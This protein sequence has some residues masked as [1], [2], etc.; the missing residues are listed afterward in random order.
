MLSSQDF[1]PDRNKSNLNACQKGGGSFGKS[2]RNSSPLL[3]F[4]ED[5]FNNMAIFIESSIELSI[6][7][8]VFSWWNYRLHLASPVLLLV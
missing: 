2:S 8:P 6:M 3:N 7:L 5:I 4:R 1:S